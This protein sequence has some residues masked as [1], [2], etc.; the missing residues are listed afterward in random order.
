[1]LKGMFLRAATT[2][3]ESL[4]GRVFG[5]E[6]GQGLTEYAILIGA[7]AFVAAFVFVGFDFGFDD[8]AAEI[9]NCITF[10]ED[11]GDA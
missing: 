9:Q 3:V 1:M 4:L 7:I 11:C 5:R 2:V 10:D 6:R 8:L